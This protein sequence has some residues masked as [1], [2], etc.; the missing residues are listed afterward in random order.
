MVKKAV[1]KL[2][3]LDELAQGDPNMI[4]ALI[5]WKMRKRNPDMTV[6]IKQE[7]LD[8]F[9]A[10][11]NYLKV[12]PEVLIKRP[13]AIPAQPGIPAT[14]NRRAVQAREEIPARP[15][16]VVN[17]VEAGT[18]NTIRPIENNQQDYDEQQQ[19]ARIMRARDNAPMLAGRLIA[20]ANSGEYSLS[21]M[22]DAAQTLQMLSEA[23]SSAD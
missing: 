4:I 6:L 20:Q 2:D 15:Y 14:H 18:T 13:P 9:N 10:C 21:D 3:Q 22:T 8:G 12:T 17:L 7:D 16:V 23:L 1:P 19:R 11:V 5:L